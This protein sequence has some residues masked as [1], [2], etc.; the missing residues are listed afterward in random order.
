[1]GYRSDVVAVIYPDA[2]SDEDAA[3]KYEQLKVLMQTT[4]KDVMEDGFG[5]DMEWVDDKQVL[6]F[7][8]Q[9]VKWYDSYPD[10]R[11]FMAMLHD[12][13]C[14][15]NEGDDVIGGYCTEFV[16]IGEDYDDV[17][18]ETHGHNQCYYLS[19]SRGIVCDV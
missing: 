4:F 8:I 18:R 14:D 7:D 5:G 17:E 3:L 19:V 10:V 12:L 1:M 6:K 16:R 2:T 15:A 13:Y 9:N 11:R